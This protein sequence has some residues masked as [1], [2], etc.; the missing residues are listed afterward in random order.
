MLCDISHVGVRYDSDSLYTLVMISNKAKLVD[1]RPKTLPSRKR[2]SVDD[3]TGE[4]AGRFDLRVHGFR[5]FGEVVLVEPRLQVHEHDGMRGVKVVVDHGF[6][7][8]FLLQL[9]R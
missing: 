5:E 6:L 2:W 1:H 8:S 4:I 7:S 9:K 3:D